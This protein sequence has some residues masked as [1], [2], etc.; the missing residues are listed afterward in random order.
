M[1]KYFII[2]F[3]SIV[4]IGCS[5]KTFAPTD[6]QLSSM[7]QKVPGITLENATAGYKLY[8]EKCAGCHQLYHPDKYTIAKWNTILLKM[9]P[10]AKLSAGEQQ[11]LIE[12]YVRAMSK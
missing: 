3:I 9:F 8:S 1:N 11:K 4:V 6:Q 12:D 5:A 10:K 7:Q 2:I